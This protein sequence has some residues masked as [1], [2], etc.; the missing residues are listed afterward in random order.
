MR[1]AFCKI[2]ISVVGITVVTSVAGCGGNDAPGA[3][4]ASSVAAPSPSSPPVDVDAAFAQFMKAVKPFWCASGFPSGEMAEAGDVGT[5][6][7]R[8][9][10]YRGVMTTWDDNLGRIAVPPAAQPIVGKLR[11]LNAAEMAGLDALAAAAEKNDKKQMKRLTGL[12]NLD[13]ATASLETGRLSAALGHPEPQAGIAFNQ[14]EV[15]YHTFY[16]DRAPMGEKFEAALSRND[17]NGAKA[18]NAIEQDAAQRFIDRLDTI[19]WPA[20]FEG[21]VNVLRDK[22]RWVIEFDRRQVDVATTAQIVPPEEGASL[23]PA[24]DDAVDSLQNRLLKLRAESAPE[25]AC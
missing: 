24:V 22:L 6:K 21:Q 10:E 14:V 1:R 25:L 18:A 19:D 2:W 3:P 23:L 15:A 16:K 13:D 4:S 12:L 17:L 8:V 9:H 5:M 20:Q 7:V 11:E